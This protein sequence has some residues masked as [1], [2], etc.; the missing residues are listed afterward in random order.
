MGTL[1]AVHSL[2]APTVIALA[3]GLSKGEI[4]PSAWPADAKTTEALR[5]SRSV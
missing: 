5:P 2:K 3:D 1:P 4:V